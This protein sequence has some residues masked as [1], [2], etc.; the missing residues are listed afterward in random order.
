[1]TIC[2]LG[3]FCLLGLMISAVAERSQRGKGEVL[4]NTWIIQKDACILIAA[5]FT[6]AKTWKQPQCPLTGMDQEHVVHTHHE[7][8]LSHKKD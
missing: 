6:I 3:K 2:G 7:V 5:I 8:K 1:M 4:N